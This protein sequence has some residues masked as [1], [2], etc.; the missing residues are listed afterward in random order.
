[1]KRFD[2]NLKKARDP[3]EIFKPMTVITRVVSND[4]EDYI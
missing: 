1:V 4:F 2:G 3:T